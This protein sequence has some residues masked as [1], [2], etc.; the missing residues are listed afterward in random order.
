M[1]T[2]KLLYLFAARKQK[3]KEK[4]V[5]TLEKLSNPVNDVNR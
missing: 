3:E 1:L 4:V 5:P 2:S